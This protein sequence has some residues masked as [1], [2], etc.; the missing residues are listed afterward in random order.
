MFLIGPEKNFQPIKL[1]IKNRRRVMGAPSF[2]ECPDMLDA[3]KKLVKERSDVFNHIE[4]DMIEC[5]VR[6]DKPAPAKQKG[7][8]KIKGIRG[9]IA[10]LTD[11]KYIIY[12]YKSQWDVLPP[13]KRYAH[14]ANQLI[15]I[16]YPSREELNELAEK[17]EAYEWGKLKKPD[18]NDFK[19]FV[20]GL[21]L[22]WDEDGA[23]VPDIIK[24]KTEL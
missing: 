8:L 7:I 5:L 18:I 17:G 2:I 15:R 1:R 13:E 16:E 21:G 20:R 6:D 23:I 19:S 11:K 10:A 3:V 14:V 9:P 22:D 24:E 12:G 4:L